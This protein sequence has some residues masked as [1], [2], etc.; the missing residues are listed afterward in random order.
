VVD[1]PELCGLQAKDAGYFAQVCGWRM[2]SETACSPRSGIR[3]RHPSGGPMAT[4]SRWFSG[5]TART[6][7]Q[8]LRLLK[9]FPYGGSCDSASLKPVVMPDGNV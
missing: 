2:W 3:G 1:G 4:T 5:W 6:Q 8:G 7:S 9:V